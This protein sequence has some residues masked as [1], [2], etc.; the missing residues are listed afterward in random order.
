MWAVC[1]TP[2]SEAEKGRFGGGETYNAQGFT[3]ERREVVWLIPHEGRQTTIHLANL[4]D[5]ARFDTWRQTKRMYQDKK[6]NLH[7]IYK[8]VYF[9]ACQRHS[10]RRL[11]PTNASIAPYWDLV[12]M[13][14][15]TSFEPRSATWREF[16]SWFSFT[17]KAWNLQ[18]GMVYTRKIQICGF[19]CWI[20][21]ILIV[22]IDIPR[23][24][25][26]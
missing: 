16:W 6:K 15:D 24:S 18:E 13:Y 9:R 23:K 8:Q 3:I 21:Q 19:F 17:L 4:T 12:A 10:G 11:A 1:I 14:Q 25:G 20:Y 2:T 22:I 5:R 7:L 26:A